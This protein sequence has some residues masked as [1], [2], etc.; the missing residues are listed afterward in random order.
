MIT[1]REFR[2]AFFKNIYF[3]RGAELEL[4]NKL[5]E[6]FNKSIKDLTE[7]VNL[8]DLS[9][10]YKNLTNPNHHKVINVQFDILTFNGYDVY[11][12]PSNFGLQNNEALFLIKFDWI[13]PPSLSELISKTT[14]YLIS[15]ST[16]Y[17]LDVSN[18]SSFQG[19]LD[20]VKEASEMMIEERLKSQDILFLEYQSD[21]EE[22]SNLKFDEIADIFFEYDKSKFH[23]YLI[24]N[25]FN[26][27]PEFVDFPEES[28]R[29]SLSNILS[30]YP[31]NSWELSSKK[32]DGL[33]NDCG[34]VVEINWFKR[35]L[36][37][38]GWSNY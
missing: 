29:Y 34:T 32:Q 13:N 33:V 27:V 12:K 5:I 37:V 28:N 26:N 2:I 38:V 21:F 25:G 10:Q 8:V 36:T 9:L 20:I 11:V 22:T 15:N 19:I 23:N 24:L 7:I 3:T 4:S 17:E 31:M 35:N 16:E 1:L 30:S 18:H 6:F 14:N